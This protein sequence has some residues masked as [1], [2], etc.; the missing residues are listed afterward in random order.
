MLSLLLQAAPFPVPQSYGEGLLI[1]FSLG[2]I[3]IILR[4]KKRGEEKQDELTK[5]REDDL[6][7]RDE[8]RAE[9]LLGIRAS[10][11]AM[12]NMAAGLRDLAQSHKETHTLLVQFI[13][14]FQRERR[15]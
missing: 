8:E 5:K 9:Q 1:L 15:S 6:A 2:A 4:D 7:R 14:E 3:G 11:D 13:S 12:G 10:T